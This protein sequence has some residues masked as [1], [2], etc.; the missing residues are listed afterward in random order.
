MCFVV[1]VMDVVFS[2]CIL[3]RGAVG[4]CECFVMHVLYVYVL[5]ASC[6]SYQCFFL[7]DLQF[8]N[9]GRGCKRRPNGRRLQATQQSQTA[10]QIVSNPPA[11]AMGDQFTV[12]CASRPCGPAEW[13]AV[14]LIKANHR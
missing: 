6:G 14:L 3:R 2:A 11:P 7:H 8:V 12:F 9:A 4:K 10:V 5:C 1:D 13:L